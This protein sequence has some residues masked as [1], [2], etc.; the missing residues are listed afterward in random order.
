MSNK[1]YQKVFIYIYLNASDN[2]LLLSFHDFMLKELNL[3]ASVTKP[4]VSQN[5]NV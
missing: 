3:I 1:L 5:L 4:A 2:F